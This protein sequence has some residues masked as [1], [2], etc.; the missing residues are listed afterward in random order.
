MS[1]VF[2]RDSGFAPPV[3]VRGEGVYIIDAEG[4]RYLDASR[5]AASG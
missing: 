5:S 3:A 1:H 2:Y 4:K